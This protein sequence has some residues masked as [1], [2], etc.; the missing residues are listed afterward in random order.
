[1]GFKVVVKDAAPGYKFV[2]WIVTLDTDP[3]SAKIREIKVNYNNPVLVIKGN[4]LNTKPGLILVPESK[5]DHVIK[6][7]DRLSA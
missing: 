1:M 3:G 6:G 5:L 2:S 7:Y 4:T